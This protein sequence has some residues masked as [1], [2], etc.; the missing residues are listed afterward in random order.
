MTKAR[1]GDQ[2]MA[3][4]RR[5]TKAKKAQ[6]EAS[7]AAAEARRAAQES[8]VALRDLAQA[9]ATQLKD[10]GLDEKAADAF[11]KVKASETYG[12]AQAKATEVGRKVAENDS[13]AAASETAAKQSAAALTGLGSWLATSPRGDKL[14]ITTSKKR[15]GGGWFFALL[16]V[17]IGYAIGILTAPREGSEMRSQL[18]NR[19]SQWNGGGDVTSIEGDP[20]VLAPSGDPVLA[21]KVRTR[22]GEDPRTSDLPALNINVV[23]GTVVVRGPA[24]D[25]DES[26]VREVVS[27]ID[28]VTAVDLELGSP[29]A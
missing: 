22:L 10:L 6:L 14:G 16:G 19:G 26:A 13:F 21:D 18:T 29:S 8:A 1:R 15:R 11:E 25:V 23:D 27:G 5:K 28:G 17:G 7:A 2:T 9:L 24:G 3:V 4:L 12:K 20:G